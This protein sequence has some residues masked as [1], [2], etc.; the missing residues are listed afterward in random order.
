MTAYIP[1]KSAA[2]GDRRSWAKMIFLGDA[3]SSES[4]SI[5]VVNIKTGVVAFADSSDRSSANRGQRSTA[6]KLAKNLKK[7]IEDDEKH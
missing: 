2:R 1:D 5:T 6:E 3:R 4:A 7:K